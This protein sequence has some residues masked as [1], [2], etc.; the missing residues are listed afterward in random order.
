MVRS[1]DVWRI[2]TISPLYRRIVRSTSILVVL[3]ES[4][5]PW[6][7][8]SLQHSTP[9]KIGHTS[10]EPTTSSKL[11]LLPFPMSPDGLAVRFVAH[12]SPWTSL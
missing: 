11:T 2:E 7:V 8:L 6:N 12:V 10:L 3:V 1:K 5:S 4:R 9:N